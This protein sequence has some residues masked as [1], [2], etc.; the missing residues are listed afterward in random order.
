MN[1]MF[2]LKYIDEVLEPNKDD[3]QVIL[4]N[5]LSC[6]HNRQI[7]ENNQFL[8][9]GTVFSA[10]FCYHV[11][12]VF[13]REI[14]AIYRSMHHDRSKKMKESALK[15]YNLVRSKTIRSYFR[16]CELTLKH[17]RNL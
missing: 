3:S 12:T 16:Q 14:R 6:H 7:L 13:F 5:N 11:T 10:R 15:A 4:M 2:M 9:E 1:T 8:T 17:R